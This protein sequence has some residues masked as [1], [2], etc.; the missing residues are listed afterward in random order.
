M[1]QHPH[2]PWG[3]CANVRMRERT[4]KWKEMGHM[5]EHPTMLKGAG[6]MHEYS[7]ALKGGAIV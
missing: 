6:H 5:C 4:T 1:C 3:G 2:S 7:P